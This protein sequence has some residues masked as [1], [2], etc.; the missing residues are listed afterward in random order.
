MKINTVRVHPLLVLV[1]VIFGMSHTS[2][3]DISCKEECYGDK[4]CEIEVE[5][6]SIVT[7]SF[8]QVGKE[9]LKQETLI[10]LVKTMV[11]SGIIF[12]LNKYT[13]DKVYNKTIDIVWD[14]IKGAGSGSFKDTFVEMKIRDKKTFGIDLLWLAGDLLVEYITKSIMA[15]DESELQYKYRKSICWWIKLGYIDAKALIN[16]NKFDASVD[17]VYGSSKVLKEMIVEINATMGEIEELRWDV[18]Y[19]DALFDIRQKKIEVMKDYTKTHLLSIQ[20]Q[21]LT[22]MDHIILGDPCCQEGLNCCQNEGYI[23]EL[24]DL[25]YTDYL[26][27]TDYLDAY[28]SK[29]RF[30]AGQIKEEIINFHKN[31]LYLVEKL[32]E[33]NNETDFIKFVENFFNAEDAEYLKKIFNANNFDFTLKTSNKTAAHKYLKKA[34]AYGFNIEDFLLNKSIFY[35]NA[36][37]SEER[38]V[39]LLNDAYLLLDR[40][41]ET[42]IYDVLYSQT[43]VATRRYFTTLLNTIFSL[44][45]SFSEKKINTLKKKG[46]ILDG[47]VGW[48]Y[49]A[50]VLK[51]HRI[52]T[53]HGIGAENQFKPDDNITMYELLK[54]LINAMDY[55]ICNKVGCGSDYLKVIDYQ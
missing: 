19:A 10:K 16:P 20:K 24:S 2:L 22:L 5:V 41:N 35:G 52:A 38:A 26:K 17:V 12:S 4:S 39:M 34:I 54:M 30:L 49:D 27:G 51:H 48:F 43:K 45:E 36:K 40:K 13:S 18:I 37:M 3:A 21:K 53:G 14:S 28:N 50:L 42:I 7:D 6:C 46:N 15:L 55:K 33:D 25:S 11:G 32:I 44:D 8:I 9:T 31:K 29:I 1:L 47:S 23:L